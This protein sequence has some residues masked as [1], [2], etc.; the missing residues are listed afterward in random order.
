MAAGNNELEAFCD[1][2]EYSTTVNDA[3]CC[4]PDVKQSSEYPISEVLLTYEQECFSINSTVLTSDATQMQ[5]NH[6]SE[7]EEICSNINIEMAQESEVVLHSPLPNNCDTIQTGSNDEFGV[8]MTYWDEFYERNYYYNSRTHE[9]TW[10]APPVMEHLASVYVP[11]DNKEEKLGVLQNGVALSD[12]SSTDVNEHRVEFELAAECFDN[13]INLS[14]TENCFNVHLNETFEVNKSTEKLDTE[15]DVVPKKRKKKVKRTRASVDNK[16]LLLT[17]S[18]YL[19]SCILYLLI[20]TFTIH[21]AS[22]W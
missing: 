3:V 22:I 18:M 14:S 6:M 2:R 10:D 1:E 20:N 12:E 16:G 5:A 8:W 7:A 4:S 17:M 13:V 9:S 21:R 11:N 15:L 19:F